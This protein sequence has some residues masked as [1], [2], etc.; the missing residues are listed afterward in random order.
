[1]SEEF[2]GVEWDEKKSTWNATHRGFGFDFAANVFHDD[3]VESESCRYEDGEPR[4]VVIG[5]VDDL[6]ITVIWTPRGANRRIISARPA[7]KRE[8]RI[9][10]GHRQKEAL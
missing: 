8:R 4:F 9:Y 5:C 10:H 2:D 6:V 7:S 1:V 3:Y